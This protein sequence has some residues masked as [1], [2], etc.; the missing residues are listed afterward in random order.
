MKKTSLT[1]LPAWKALAAHHAKIR[2]V[3]LRTLFAEDP[4]R[5]KRLTAE[6]AGLFLKCQTSRTGSAA[7]RGRGAPESGFATWSTSASAGPT[8]DR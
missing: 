4:D 5:G 1:T 6:A 8:T 7:A 3:H 2:D